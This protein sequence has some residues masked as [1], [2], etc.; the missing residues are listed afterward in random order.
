[1]LDAMKSIDDVE[2]CNFISVID[3]TVVERLNRYCSNE[4]INA[5]TFEELEEEDIE[6]TDIVSLGEK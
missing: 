4:E 5:V 1:M 2:D 6:T 3:F